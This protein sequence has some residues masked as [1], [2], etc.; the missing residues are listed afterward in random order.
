MGDELL[1]IVGFSA[2]APAEPPEESEAYHA[3]HRRHSSG[4]GGERGQRVGHQLDGDDDD[5][6]GEPASVLAAIAR[7][8]LGAASQ[9]Q[10]GAALHDGEFAI[11]CLLLESRIYRDRLKGGP[12][13]V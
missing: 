7:P 13:V 9:H 10:D 8:P 11:K 6:G 4:G 2:E 1:F 12:Q 5:D 3:H